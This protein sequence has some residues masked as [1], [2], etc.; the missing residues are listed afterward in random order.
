MLNYTT[1]GRH[2]YAL[3][4]PQRHQLSGVKTKFVEMMVY[5]ISAL[6]AGSWA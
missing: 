4:Q 5:I 1:Y 2:V 3:A 6:M